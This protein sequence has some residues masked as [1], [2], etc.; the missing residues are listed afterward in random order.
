ML[1]GI[2]KYFFFLASSYSM[3]PKIAAYCSSK[4]KIFRYNFTAVKLFLY[5]DRGKI[6]I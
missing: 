6:V 5:F 4:A 3:Q 2:K 1:V